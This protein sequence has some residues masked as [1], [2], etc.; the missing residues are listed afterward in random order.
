MAECSDKSIATAMKCL[1]IAF[2]CK[3]TLYSRHL[4]LQE[5][6]LVEGRVTD[7]CKNRVW[8]GLFWFGFLFYFAV[9]ILVWGLFLFD[10]SYIR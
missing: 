4:H 5:R 7:P 10:C 1:V 8:F 9:W 6:Y 3:T 2:C